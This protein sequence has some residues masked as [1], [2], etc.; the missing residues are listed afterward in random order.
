LIVKAA[1]EST[2]YRWV[3]DTDEKGV[4]VGA[5]GIELG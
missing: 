2:N 1:E 4:G 3:A 5:T